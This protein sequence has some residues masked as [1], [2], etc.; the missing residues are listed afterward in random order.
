MLKEGAAMGNNQC[1]EWGILNA[2]KIQFLDTAS[3]P[4][5]V[6]GQCPGQCRCASRRS[7]VSITVIPTSSP[8]QLVEEVLTSV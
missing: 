2:V 7:M 8:G 5:P 1:L 3:G 6:G 4:Q